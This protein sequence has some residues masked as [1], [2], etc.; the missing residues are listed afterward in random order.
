MK[1]YLLLLLFILAGFMSTDVQKEIYTIDWQISADQ[2]NILGY[3]FSDLEYFDKDSHLP[4]FCKVFQLK[5]GE[6]TFQFALDNA[7]FEEFE[8]EKLNEYAHQFPGKQS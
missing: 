3:T 4:F 7:V 1:I 8:N 6:S 5:K 2:E